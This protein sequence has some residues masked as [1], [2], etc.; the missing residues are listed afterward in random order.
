MLSAR[1]SAPLVAILILLV[2]MVT[3]CSAP[4]QS[5]QRREL[6]EG[7]RSLVTPSGL[8][9][10]LG[11]IAQYERPSGSEGENAAIDHIVAVLQGDG[12]PVDV[13]TFQA[14]AS[15]PVSATIEVV[16]ADLE[17]EAIT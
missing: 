7:V 5:S 6:A 11:A 10:Q 3:G 17:P 15:D 12:I 8:E 2:P 9:E 1:R 16:G 14:Y 4:H 13:Y